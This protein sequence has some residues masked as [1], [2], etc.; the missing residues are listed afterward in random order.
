MATGLEDVILVGSYRVTKIITLFYGNRSKQ[1]WK[2]S[3]KVNPP[4]TNGKP[5]QCLTYDSY[6]IEP[7]ICDKDLQDNLFQKA[8]IVL[9][10]LWK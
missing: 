4:R 1:S 10:F 8:N 7:G 2:Y 5:S 3:K 6:T 9:C